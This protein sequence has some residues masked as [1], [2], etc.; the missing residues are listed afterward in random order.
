M[1]KQ[2]TE[3]HDTGRREEAKEHERA[4]GSVRGDERNMT[5]WGNIDKHHKQ[6]DDRMKHEKGR[7]TRH[8]NSDKIYKD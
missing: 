6:G 3:E 4:R 2:E 7:E 1:T 5:D 8:K